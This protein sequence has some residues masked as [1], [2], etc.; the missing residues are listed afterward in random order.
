MEPSSGNRRRGRPNAFSEAEL[1]D[2]GGRA[3]LSPRHLQNRAHALRARRRLAGLRW[4]QEVCGDPD[5]PQCVL[6]ELGRIEDDAR[7]RD[8]VWWH[9]YSGRD[10]S[11]KQAAEA[12]KRMRTGKTP[13]EGPV[14]LY[15]RLM[16]TVED[17]RRTYPDASVRYQEGQVEL[18]LQTV[19]LAR[20]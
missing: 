7:F 3:S 15:R 16:R 2:A 19:R 11:A 8:A 9:W 5:V 1:K 18:V 17:F 13:E 20:R 6:C 14:T 10:L 12:L 4:W